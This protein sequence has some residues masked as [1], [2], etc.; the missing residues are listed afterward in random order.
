MVQLIGDRDEIIFIY[1]QD[2]QFNI[3]SHWTEIPCS[4]KCVVFQ[5]HK[6]NRYSDE[7]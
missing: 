6:A 7:S 4:K 2:F 3:L 1:F 5:I